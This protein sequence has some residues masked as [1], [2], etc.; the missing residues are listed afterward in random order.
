[1]W[2]PLSRLCSRSVDDRDRGTVRPAERQHGCRRGL[3]HGDAVLL[4]AALG[5]LR[6]RRRVRGLQPLRRLGV[7]L[8]RA[9]SRQRSREHT[10][11]GCRHRGLGCRSG[12]R[13]AVEEIRLVAPIDCVQGVMRR[14]VGHGEPARHDD[15]VVAGESQD[16]DG[17]D[18]PIRHLIGAGRRW[19]SREH[20]PAPHKEEGEAQQRGPSSVHGAPPGWSVS[21]RERGRREG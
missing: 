3:P 19:T 18:V 11:H 4:R 5:D 15:V 7:L 13:P 8:G 16:I 20:E 2:P 10:A 14:Q 17:D 12:L 9:E 1:M 6:E 21:V